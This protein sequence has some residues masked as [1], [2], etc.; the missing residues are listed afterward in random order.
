MKVL[1]FEFF[2]IYTKMLYL[3]S[4]NKNSNIKKNHQKSLKIKNYK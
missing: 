1:K 2:I 3:Y 4:E